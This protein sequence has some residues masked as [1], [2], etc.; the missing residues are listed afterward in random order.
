MRI[1]FIMEGFFIEPLGIMQLSACLKKAGHETDLVTTEEGYKEKI[2]EWKPE[3]I[4]YSVMTGNHKNFLE[5]NKEL[6]KK[7]NFISLF[8]GPHAT[9]FRDLI[10]EDGVDVVCI[11][12]GD[13]AV[14]ELA[15]RLETGENIKTIPNLNVKNSGEIYKNTVRDL[16]EDLDDLPF[17]DRE[18][19]NKYEKIRN[20]PIK[21][22][23]AGRGCPYNCRYCF[24]EKYAE[25]YNGKGRRVRF[26][27]VNNVIEEVKD[28][29]NKYSTRVVYFQDDTFILNKEWLREFSE[30]YKEIGLPF[31]CHV[32]ANLVDEEIVRLLK[33]ANCYSVHIAAETADDKLR[34]EVLNRNMSK[35]EI[36]NAC[37]LLRKYR[38]RFM[39]QSMIG[40]PGGSLEKDF[41]TLK[42]NIK[43]KPTYAW[44]SIF[45]PYP[46]T[47]LEK[48]CKEN[49]YLEDINYDDI[50]SNF[51]ER[52][53]LNIEDKKKIEHLQRWFGYTVEHPF[54]YY[55]GLLKLFISFPRWKGLNRWYRNL[56][57]NFRDRKDNELYGVELK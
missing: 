37:K 39:M 16:I 56:Y 24:N 51:Y 52:S 53:I 6:K 31:H 10:E 32:R 34:N 12:E 41:E 2:R 30:K 46:G 55:S 9:F 35:E 17:P 7:F 29:I 49:G 22:F 33:E 27:S 42:L 11:G 13:E 18:I 44:V 8:G 48:Y 38:I 5:L 19:V 20:D 36:I 43:C 15:N 54:L 47:E 26:R 14:V 40:L 57:R 23:I 28:V 4:A 3:I 25:V 21:H 45:Q 50:A 1:L